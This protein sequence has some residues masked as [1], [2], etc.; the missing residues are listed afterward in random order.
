M[1]EERGWDPTIL[2]FLFGALRDYP[3]KYRARLLASIDE[4]QRMLRKWW[5]MPP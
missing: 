5:G 2:G 4:V 3:E 1:K